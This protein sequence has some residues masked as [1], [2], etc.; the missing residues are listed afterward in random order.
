MQPTQPGQGPTKK[1]VPK[2][3]PKEPVK[4][5][6]IVTP[7]EPVAPFPP[8]PVV[9]EPE[10]PMPLPR[11]REEPE[12]RPE[13]A[14]RW[15]LDIREEQALI[16]EA[17]RIRS[18][19]EGRPPGLA[20]P[21]RPDMITP[22]ER[23]EMR[24]MQRHEERMQRPGPE[25]QDLFKLVKGRA[26][27]ELHPETWTPAGKWVSERIAFEPEPGRRPTA[28]YGPE[29]GIKERLFSGIQ[30]ATETLADFQKREAFA[31]P[32]RL[33]GREITGFW[34]QQLRGASW[35]L[36][37]GLP[38]TGRAV[39]AAF[40]A[41][42]PYRDKAAEQSEREG[43]YVSPIGLM[44]RE[45]LE[46]GEAA[47]LRTH[48][49]LVT[50]WRVAFEDRGWTMLAEPQKLDL[51]EEHLALGHT[52]EEILEDPELGPNFWVEFGMQ[53]VTDPW[54]ALPISWMEKIFPVGR[55]LK[56]G[57]RAF[58]VLD[59]LAGA[60]MRKVPV[61]DLIANKASRNWVA[62]Y[63]DDVLDGV[64]Y[65]SRTEVPGAPG[66]P[67]TEKLARLMTLDEDVLAIIPQR[68]QPTIQDMA[69][70]VQ[71][72]GWGEV[73]TVLQ[74]GTE[75][76][77]AAIPRIMA[78]AD[79][80]LAR[81]FA[82]AVARAKG[83]DLGLSYVT[84]G[85]IGRSASWGMRFLKEGWLH[86]PAM[87]GLQTAD[88]WSRAAIYSHFCSPFDTPGL[89]LL[90][91][92]IG[93]RPIAK[94]LAA[95][96]TALGAPVPAEL[97][98]AFVTAVTEKLPGKPSAWGA[99][100]VP[101]VGK[102]AAV[103]DV[104]KKLFGD[105]LI[106]QYP[107]LVNLLEPQIALT[108]SR[109]V[110]ETAPMNRGIL[111]RVLRNLNIASGLDYLGELTRMSDANV[112]YHIILDTIRRQ[113]PAA[114]EEFIGELTERLQA[115]GIADEV[116]E[117]VTTMLRQPH[118]IS[119][120]DVG[121]ILRRFQVDASPHAS[122]ESFDYS[123]ISDEGQEILRGL[124]DDLVELSNRWVAGDTDIETE[125]ERTFR[126][127]MAWIGDIEEESALE[128]IG[129]QIGERMG[130][131]LAEMGPDFYYPHLFSYQ[132]GELANIANL[133]DEGPH[134]LRSLRSIVR[135]L[136]YED[137]GVEALGHRIERW[138][139]LGQLPGGEGD[140]A[141]SMYFN[142]RLRDA[143]RSGAKLPAWAR[144]I[145]YSD[146][147]KKYAIRKITQRLQGI[148]MVEGDW[149][150]AGV[151]YE[152]L[153]DFVTKLGID[154]AD[155]ILRPRAGLVPTFAESANPAIAEE[156]QRLR[157]VVDSWLNEAMLK[158]YTGLDM[159]AQDAGQV[160]ALKGVEKW[161]VSAWQNTVDDLVRQGVERR[162]HILF[163]F[164]MRRNLDTLAS[165]IFPFH[166]WQTR[167]IP[168]AAQVLAERPG[169]LAALLR[170]VKVGEEVR[171]LAGMPESWSGYV[172]LPGGEVV[173]NLL[174]LDK[175]PLWV[176]PRSVL[177]LGLLSQFREPFELK[178]KTL[179][180]PQQVAAI[181]ARMG[182]GT[183]PWI[184]RAGRMAGV[185]P[186]TE[187]PAG[188][189]TWLG[190]AASAALG[191]ENVEEAI[192]DTILQRIGLDVTPPMENPI[193]NYYANLRLVDRVQRGEITK[194]QADQAI[195]NPQ[196]AL[197]RQALQDSMDERSK[198]SLLRAFQ[199]FSLRTMTAER[200][201]RRAMV[202]D[203]PSHA[204]YR[205]YWQS[206]EG[207]ARLAESDIWKSPEERLAQLEIT[208][209]WDVKR[210]FDKITAGMID[211]W[212]ASRPG[213]LKGVRGL[214]AKRYAEF[215]GMASLPDFA[216]KLSE[217]ATREERT[218]WYRDIIRRELGNLR[219]DADDFT[220]FDEE[221]RE[222][223]DWTAYNAATNDHWNKVERLA[224][225]E[226]AWAVNGLRHLL[227]SEQEIIALIGG[228]EGVIDYWHRNDSILQAANR[229]WEEHIL[230]PALQA[231]S[232][233]RDLK[234][235]AKSQA[236]EQLFQRYGG[237]EGPGLLE[238]ILTRYPGRW[239]Q[240]EVLAEI[241]DIRWPGLEGYWDYKYTTTAEVE[242]ADAV[243]AAWDRYNVEYDAE[244]FPGNIPELVESYFAIPSD[245]KDRRSA[246]LRDNPELKRYFEFRQRYFGENPSDAKVIA[247]DT[248]EK[249][250][251]SNFWTQYEPFRQALPASLR[252]NPSLALLLDPE[253]RV[254]ATAVQFQKGT[255]IL[256]E[257]VRANPQW[258]Q[259]AEEYRLYRA[260]LSEQMQNLETM[261]FSLESK[262]DRRTFLAAEPD[263]I[264]YWA[265]KDSFKEDHPLMV[266]YYFEG[267]KPREEAKGAAAAYTGRGWAGRAYRPWRGRGVAA[268]REPEVPPWMIPLRQR[269]II[270]EPEYARQ[271]RQR[272]WPTPPAV[273]AR[274]RPYIPRPPSRVRY[275]R[276]K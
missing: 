18:E 99:I 174:G 164:S 220:T 205:A 270:M 252:D 35:L 225:D 98:E 235:R 228:Q 230:D 52:S 78:G 5:A 60:V 166:V 187:L 250:P 106:A 142:N 254:T 100:P 80:N 118:N 64:M 71:K 189:I 154:S 275:L 253:S 226:V 178:E 201:E 73:A 144:K 259:A 124:G 173:T 217:F 153:D 247:P 143:T 192:K 141:K 56:A 140:I 12:R 186:E 7:K 102:P 88:A 84:K 75:V 28:Y 207:Q 15:Y 20:A 215:D 161:A 109:E 44:W 67:F 184:E 123:H 126:R 42:K 40:F 231:Y 74:R 77:K 196:S 155:D 37:R 208:R 169:V 9:S 17:Q 19:H 276:G 26:G 111:G 198:L 16:R 83:K 129:A 188:P 120:N 112:G 232:E 36:R 246:Y 29:P 79:D 249:I 130:P 162:H 65:L 70:M 171:Q 57:G 69:H 54:N 113:A 76:E 152:G 260:L 139:E 39:G 167:N 8:A 159:I 181:P 3:T 62:R 202:W 49:E 122:F 121:K 214:Q 183:W 258:P 147:G 48:D 72:K 27:A 41:E 25:T 251:E 104:A 213:D 224:F 176:D 55:A 190:R 91:R 195:N 212:I 223:I 101:L 175:Q 262:D 236:I 222:V 31:E 114:K 96:V 145:V 191:M 134:F 103:I 156:A 248:A 21:I 151:I 265:M 136:G 105:S 172:P 82:E 10:R 211:G 58:N 241:R 256:R 115:G 93:R 4:P 127:Y 132:G 266:R 51:F 22:E 261:Y 200:V 219:P 66:M 61:L 97:G 133:P 117:Q 210:S 268:A 206:R 163:D 185:I 131:E 216:N 263:L 233:I 68:L 46:Q 59:E 177:S 30:G 86:Q 1:G 157:S 13:P 209:A 234:G 245:Q 170:Y 146:E 199:P 179:T 135:E 92:L 273:S 116:I 193:E 53:T 110:I 138:A 38:A 119:A 89:H 271:Q 229:V 90:N 47:P 137:E 269:G 23:R 203:F 165:T 32:Y 238:W 11:E 43:L 24:A 158:F 6:P 242:A 14:D 255:T 94:Q 50:S 194:E 81:W 274:R 239:T 272:Q 85:V 149:P 125:L 240:A 221:G 243:D 2:V 63:S 182:I 33:F 34:G 264:A 227:Y 150:A 107:W 180:L 148:R 108:A 204:A 128:M 87:A 95:E 237:I 160:K 267:W 218:E 168:F 244:G 197:F 45:R 257:F